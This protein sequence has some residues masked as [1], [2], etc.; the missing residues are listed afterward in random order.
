MYFAVEEGH[1]YSTY[2]RIVDPLW[3]CLDSLSLSINHQEQKKKS[4]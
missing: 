3:P 4:S 1:Q 2:S